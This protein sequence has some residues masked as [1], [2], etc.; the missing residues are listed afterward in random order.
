MQIFM[1]EHEKPKTKKVWYRKKLGDHECQSLK[2]A[3]QCSGRRFVSQ[4]GKRPHAE[5]QPACTQL[6][7]KPLSSNTDPSSQRNTNKQNKL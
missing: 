7:G 6:K 5:K 1:K 2:P 3:C 4:L